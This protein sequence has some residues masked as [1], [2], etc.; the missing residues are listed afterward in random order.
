MGPFENFYR[1]QIDYRGVT[2]T[3]NIFS[4]D[5]CYRLFLARLFVIY[6]MMGAIGVVGAPK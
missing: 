6:R 2:M 5:G 4:D 1:G 3:P